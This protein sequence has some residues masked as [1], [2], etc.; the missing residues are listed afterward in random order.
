M[1]LQETLDRFDKKF[2]TDEGY[3]ADGYH[4]T[5]DKIDDFFKSAI[6][7]AQEEVISEIPDG[8]IIHDQFTGGGRDT[9]GWEFKMH[10][11]EKFLK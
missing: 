1:T 10:L 5:G 3:Y 11:R 9:F 2:L 4:S 7:Q 8:A 6:Q